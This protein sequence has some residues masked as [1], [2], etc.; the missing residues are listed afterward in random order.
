MALNANI[1]RIDEIEPRRINNVGPRRMAHVIASRSMAFLATDIPFRDRFFL[2]VVVD[3]MA[4]VAQRPR[5]PL[6]VVRRVESRPPIGAVP[7]EI[8][9]PYLV[10]NIPLSGQHNV[11][12]SY[13]LEI[14]LFPL[15]AVYEGD[16]FLVELD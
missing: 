7:N 14:A 16:I 4:S 10:R 9:T 2:N 13:F 12:V 3:R 1:V 8:R 15:A 11:V 5:R 6:H